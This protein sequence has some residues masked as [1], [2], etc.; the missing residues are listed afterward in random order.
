MTVSIV[1]DPAAHYPPP[2]D[3][4][5]PDEA[6]PEYAQGHVSARPN[7]IYTL[8]RR[9]LSEHGLDK[10]RLGTPEWNPLR[11]LVPEGSRVFVLCN[12]VY[13]RRPHES[14]A[15]LRAK[16]IHGSV[17]RA[18]IDYALLAVG[19]S[20]RVA[21][22][23]SS[24]QSCNFQ[25]VLAD[26]GAD[27]VEEFYRARGLPVRAR[28]LR[29]YVAARNALGRVTAVERRDERDGVELDLGADSLLAGLQAVAPGGSAPY[30][31]TDYDPRRIEA[32]HAAGHHRYVVHRE[33]LESDV[34]ISLSKLK[35]HE[36]VGITCGLKGFVGSVGHKDCLAH[37]RFG[38]PRSGGDEYPDYLRALEPVSRF[39]DWV[40]RRTPQAPLQAFA[41]V[42]DR[43]I[44]R[45]LRRSR[46]ITAGAWH[47]NDTAWR[48]TLD[49]ARILYYATAAGVMTPTPQRRHLSLID[50]IVAGERDGP[51][52]PRPVAAGA[53]VF[54]E[55][56]ALADRVA[57][58]LMGFDPERI[59]LIREAFRLARYPISASAAE[60]EC[61]VDDRVCLEGELAPVAGR[62]FEPTSGWKDHLRSQ[63]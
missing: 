42:A 28:D 61:R 8:V 57:A 52:N 53:L 55:D 26:A 40:N 15:A 46:A 56:V 47:G 60:A 58:R 29:L 51:L 20:G 44:R 54:G 22:G 3:A 59:P 2:D 62:P 6:W 35:T 43:S 39:H 24:L 16:C 45:L 38:A 4:F 1:T 25:K 48:M 33:V 18:L 34:V 63:T 11:D 32:F 21:F 49:L 9:L 41:Q 37:H 31:I 30:R 27:R 50:G 7:P 5:S 13:H 17:L 14:V 19:P 12:F 10:S 36:K 23:N